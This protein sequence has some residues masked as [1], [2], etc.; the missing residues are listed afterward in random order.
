MVRLAPAHRHR[1]GRSW[2]RGS[3]EPSPCGDVYTHCALGFLRLIVDCSSE[4]GVVVIT[5]LAANCGP[6][7]DAPWGG[8]AAHLARLCWFCIHRPGFETQLAAC[9]FSWSC[10]STTPVGLSRAS[11]RGAVLPV[12]I[13]GQKRKSN[14]GRWLADGLEERRSRQHTEALS[15]WS[16]TA[17]LAEP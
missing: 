5:R 15:P 4:V 10:T 11:R 2:W 12:A 14:R 9:N 8:P 16:R 1:K 7:R 17:T 13:P 3:E 6:L